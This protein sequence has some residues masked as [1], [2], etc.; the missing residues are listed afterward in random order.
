MTEFDIE[1][2][3]RKQV[4]R[5]EH[6]QK[7]AAASR[8]KKAE[9]KLSP[10][11]IADVILRHVLAGTRG[12]EL[13]RAVEVDLGHTPDDHMFNAAVEVARIRVGLSLSRNEF[14]FEEIC[15]KDDWVNWIMPMQEM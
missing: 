1:A 4:Q 5:R 12:Q 9:A 7:V 8:K 3:R 6:W 11:D 2:L 14:L 15:T 13:C 10:N